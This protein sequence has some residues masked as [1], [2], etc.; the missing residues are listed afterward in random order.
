MPY[1]GGPGAPPPVP[2]PAQMAAFAS[3]DVLFAGQVPG[4]LGRLAPHLRWVQTLGADASPVFK[5]GLDPDRVIVTN[6]AGLLADP[7]AEFVIGRILAHWKAFD[8]IAAHQ[9]AA[10]WLPRYGR[11]LAGSVLGIVGYGAIGAAVTVRAIALGMQVH[12]ASRRG[13]SLEAM[14]GD[15][16]V[17]AF[18]A[19][20]AMLGKCDAVVLCAAADDRNRNLFSHDRFGRMVHG[21]YFINVSRGSLVDEAA[22]IAALET[23]QLGGAAIDVARQEPL[24]P[25]DPLWDAPNLAISAHCSAGIDRFVERGWTL[26]LDN[27]D[28]FLAGKDLRNRRRAM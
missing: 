21:S 9:R 26:F 4:D 8:D 5:S 23:G 15:V 19:L 24:P 7:I 1:G 17:W 22:L 27:L 10:L 18:D 11:D 2:D 3:A 20:D 25:G 6:G 16:T 28:R 13:H 12:I 14:Q